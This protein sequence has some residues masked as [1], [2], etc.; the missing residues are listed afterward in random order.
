MIKEKAT[1]KSSDGSVSVVAQKVSGDIV[2]FSKTV[3]S[4]T[5]RGSAKVSDFKSRFPKEVK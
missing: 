5:V 2:H 1:Y 3:G 4:M